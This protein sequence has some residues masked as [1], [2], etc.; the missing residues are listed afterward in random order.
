M[1]DGYIL[2]TGNGT[3]NGWHNPVNWSSL[4]VPEVGDKVLFDKTSSKNV[5]F[6]RHASI[7]DLVVNGSYEGD[8]DLRG[9]VLTI[10]G[11]ADFTGARFRSSDGEIHF[12]AQTLQLLRGPTQRILAPELIHSGK[13]TVRLA[14]QLICLN[15]NLIAGAFDL[16]GYNLSIQENLEVKGG[17]FVVASLAGR[18]LGVGGDA[19]FQGAE[20][21]FLLLNPDAPWNLNVVGSLTAKYIVLANNKALQA[22][23]KADESINAGGNQNWVFP[24]APN[25]LKNPEN[26]SALVA[27]K[28]VFEISAQG[29][30][31][32]KYQWFQDGT[33]IKGAES[34]VLTLESPGLKDSGSLFFCR[35]GNSSGQAQSA[36]AR[37][38][39]SFPAPTATPSGSHFDDSV[40]VSLSV[41]VLQADIFFMRDNGDPEPYSQP[42][43]LRNTT[44]LQSFAVLKGDTSVIGKAFYIRNSPSPGTLPKPI[45]TPGATE[46]TDSLIIVTL[47]G[48][49]PNAA[50]YYKLESDG[51]VRFYE[52]PIILRT[53]TRIWAFST[54]DA[55][56]SDTVE[57]LYTRRLV[58]PTAS[59]LSRDFTDSLAVTLSAT[60]S[61]VS[62]HYTLDGS[63][64]TQASALYGKRL[65]LKQGV[66][67][68]AIA[69]AP[70]VEPS[71][72]M[73]QAYA[74]IP[75]PPVVS[76]GGG[77]FASEAEVVLHA[78]DSNAVIRYTL[79][80]TA[81]DMNSG[82][83]Y[84]APL[85]ISQ[86][87]TLRAVAIIGDGDLRRASPIISTNYRFA[88]TGPVS[89]I[90]G[91]EFRLSNHCRVTWESA[92][93]T[94]QFKA[95]PEDSLKTY[96]GFAAPECAFRL[97][98]P[99]VN[100]SSLAR[101]HYTGSNEGELYWVADG[102]RTLNL[103]SAATVT[104][105]GSGVYF[106]ARDTLAPLI[107]LEK[108]QVN[109]DGHTELEF[110]LQDNTSNL[111]VA[112]KRSDAASPEWQYLEWTTGKDL[113][114]LVENG[115][116]ASDPVRINIQ[117]GDGRQLSLFPT[118]SNST[119]LPKRRLTNYRSPSSWKVGVNGGAPWDLVSVPIAL[120]PPLTLGG[121]RKNNGVA[122][123]KGTAW[124]AAKQAYRNL[125]DEDTLPAHQAFWLSSP[126]SLK[127][128]LFHEVTSAST[129]LNGS[130]KINLREG[131]NLVSNT[132]EK[133][134]YWPGSRQ[135]L[136]T[137]FYNPIK[138]PWIYDA[139]S[140]NYF[141][142]DSLEPWRGYFVYCY[143]KEA[144]VTLL[145]KPFSAKPIAMR[146]TGSGNRMHLLLKRGNFLLLGATPGAGTG[147]SIE[148][149]FFPPANTAQIPGAIWSHREGRKLGTDVVRF[150]GESILRWRVISQRSRSEAPDSL[151]ILTKDLPF[152]WQVW[153]VSSTGPA[154]RI[155]TAFAIAL[156]PVASDTLEI[157]AG[158]SAL[159]AGH[160]LN[161]NDSPDKFSAHLS[162]NNAETLLHFSLPH[163]TRL[164]ISLYN[165]NG[166]RL[167]RIGKAE[168]PAGNYRLSLS[169]LA[170][171][172][173][174][175]QAAF[176]LLEARGP[177]TAWS[178][179][180]PL[181][182]F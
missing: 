21:A 162:H 167:N 69:Y 28:T 142:S 118:D 20:Q 48:A 92:G 74:R 10:T 55:E 127:S 23:G 81:P 182:E 165:A 173:R 95:L 113:V 116:N 46:F 15:L 128:A 149:E 161:R 105:P 98:L 176:L 19:Y 172:R 106:R 178:Q 134:L 67:L 108:E 18:T 174:A 155:D 144:S 16:N 110:T 2:W 70:G 180:L 114:L 12:T 4:T 131:W 181:R 125:R 49:A 154:R 8:W 56:T 179:S 145:E 141:P 25:I 109:A 166:V 45:F 170:P 168:W 139:N 53:T 36:A 6:Q 135:D 65:V 164:E 151:S 61:D 57:A 171:S 63:L 111:K 153:M 148:D 88:P 59:P 77:L 47:S 121:L 130:V 75:A 3:D 85:R 115:D 35:V 66:R 11:N 94:A 86:E 101:F 31:I 97:T 9:R 96:P 41:A 62:V 24:G 137:Y 123:L 157:W 138:N 79:N 175:S 72:I 80:G 68:R 64:P 163:A 133:T 103:T 87:T 104:L 143:N 132:R 27:Q 140:G 54:R 38:L 60:A 30:G 146:K 52:S 39:V 136:E 76:P 40:T 26:R 122:S 58:P 1:K 158:P 22:Q 78:A 50:L 32:L 82:I 14:S 13:G 112:I 51:L 17:S 177:N 33:P 42:I 71:A 83:I 152:D 124:D 84:Q 90:P 5:S 156:P 99:S 44:D 126:S 147:L 37:L 102:N 160:W 73:D 7:Q 91:G 93:S 34:A 89:L 119:F 117:V 120:D 129:T 29:S 43:V 169:T 107:K 100:D 150:E 159:M